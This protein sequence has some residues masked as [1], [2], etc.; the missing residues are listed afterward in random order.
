MST[1][2][3]RDPAADL[4]RFEELLDRSERVRPSGLRFAELRELGLL[5]RMHMSR[6]ARLRERGD[7][8]DAQRHLN[9]LALRCRHARSPQPTRNTLPQKS[10]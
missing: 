7:D 8:P 1:Q 5:Y 3:G 9:A 6:L 10:L 2:P 4:R